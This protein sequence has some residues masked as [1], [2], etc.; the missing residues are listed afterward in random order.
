MSDQQWYRAILARD[1]TPFHRVVDAIVATAGPCNTCTVVSDAV[2]GYNPVHDLASAVGA[3]VAAKLRAKGAAVCLLASAA[4][5][6]VTA[7]LAQE[8][9]LDDAAMARKS[10]AVRAYLPLAE[11]AQRIL[12]ADPEATAREALLE[13]G[14]DWPL[15]FKP[16]WEEFGKDRVDMGRYP[17]RITYLEHVRPVALSIIDEAS[18]SAAATQQC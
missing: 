18:I 13:G 9:R 1:A 10:E 14:F 7:T 16:Q 4:V 6:G 11:E 17:T 15:D 2:D 12:R 8:F 5:P 3:A